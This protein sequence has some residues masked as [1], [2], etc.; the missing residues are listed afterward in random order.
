VF[1]FALRLVKTELRHRKARAWLSF[2]RSEALP[3]G[4]SPSVDIESRDLLR[5]FY[6]LLDRLRPRPRLVFCLRYLERMTVEEIATSLDLSVS[7]V[8]RALAHA[9]GKLSC[10][11][12][13]DFGELGDLASRGGWMGGM[14]GTDQ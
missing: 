7:T 3:E 5:R 2:H 1:S 12:R 10:W 11:V 14:A 4:V 9:T 8:K 6:A 13:S